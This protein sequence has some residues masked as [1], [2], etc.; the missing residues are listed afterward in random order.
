MQ[1]PDAPQVV[2]PQLMVVLW[3][4]AMV[5]VPALLVALAAWLL[6][7]R[8]AREGERGAVAERLR[9]LSEL[10]DQGLIDADEYASRRAEIVDAG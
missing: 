1:S 6:W 5:L 7:R 9:Q 10:R 3:P 8:R 4:I 2:L